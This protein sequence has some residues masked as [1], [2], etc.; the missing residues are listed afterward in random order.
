MKILK[1]V[2]I[3]LAAS[4]PFIPMAWGELYRW[5]DENGVTHLSDRPPQDDASIKTMKT[6]R[7]VK[8][9][10]AKPSSSAAV[11]ETPEEKAPAATEILQNYLDKKKNTSKANLTAE[12]YTTSWCGYC[13]KAKQYLASNNIP[14]TEYDIEKDEAA[15]KRK[16]SLHPSK[17]V[18]LLVVGERKV[19]GFNEAAYDRVFE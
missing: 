3:L 9:T 13:K 10:P 5:V 7:S 19:V 2:T 18:P 1:F 11:S 8:S 4:L 15:A 14:F 6:V 16:E 17:G 12:L